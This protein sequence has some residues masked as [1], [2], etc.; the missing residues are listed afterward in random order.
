[1]A[2]GSIILS[3]RNE[4][5]AEVEKLEVCFYKGVVSQFCYTIL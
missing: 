4:Q 3:R 5:A 1:M 2:R